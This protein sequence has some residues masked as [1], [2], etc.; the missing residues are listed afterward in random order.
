MKVPKGAGIE[1]LL[2]QARAAMERAQDIER[3]LK[4]RKLKS[5]R[6]SRNSSEE[7][8]TMKTETKN[9]QVKKSFT[10]SA[11]RVFDAWLD[12]KLAS[13]FLFATPD[14]EIIK[15]EIDARVGGRF[16]IVRR[17]DQGETEHVGE[18]E[19]IDRPKK[20]AFTF[21]VPRYAPE[22]TRVKIEISP[23]AN[24]CDLTLIQEDVL[25]EWADKSAEGWTMILNAEANVLG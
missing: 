4:V 14:G 13:R 19:A 22:M 24:G 3:Q 1:G 20:L 17:D 21:G 15:C 8:Q 2:D 6:R 10:A 9:L 5:S 12:P 16:V 23:N 11:E 7:M 18:Y 25:A